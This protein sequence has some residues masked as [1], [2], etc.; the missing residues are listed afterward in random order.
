MAIDLSKAFDTVNHHLLLNDINNLPL[1]YHIKRFLCAYLRGRQT[2]V[3][4]RNSKSTYRKVKQG[5]PQGGVLS[6]ILF[7]LYMASMPSPPGSIKLVSYADDGNLLNS[8]PKI[9]PLVEELNSYLSILNT[10]FKSRNLFISPSNPPPHFLQQPRVK[11][12]PP[13]T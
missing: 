5:V 3:V 4:F 8:G 10:W 6:P 13:W 7:N 12:V 9:E 2:F 11:S 1:N